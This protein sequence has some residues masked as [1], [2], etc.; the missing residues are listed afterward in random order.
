[1]D[2]RV[3]YHCLSNPAELLSSVMLAINSNI[4]VQDIFSPS[5]LCV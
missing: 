4:E 1:M 3:V 2:S 5:R